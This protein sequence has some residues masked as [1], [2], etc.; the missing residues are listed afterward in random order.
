MFDPGGVGWERRREGEEG[1]L[2]CTGAVCYPEKQDQAGLPPA[3]ATEEAAC[4]SH[5]C[6]RD[7]PAELAHGHWRVGRT[8]G[9]SLPQTSIG[10]GWL[11][12]G[13]L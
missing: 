2:A 5:G 8:R 7:W 11:S 1:S 12:L 3:G 9:V 6:A 13:S 10:S 4:L